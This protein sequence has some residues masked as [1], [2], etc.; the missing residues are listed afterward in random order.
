MSKHK[1]TIG[2]DASI[3]SNVNLIAPV[4]IGKGATV[5][6]GSTISKSVPEGVLTVARAKQKNIEDWTRPNKKESK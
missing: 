1:T 2:D 5:G 3:G 4:S 6:A